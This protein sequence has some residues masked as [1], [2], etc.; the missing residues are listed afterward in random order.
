MPLPIQLSPKADGYELLFVGAHSDDIEIGCGG[1]IL[2]LQRD[3]RVRRVTWAVLTG[4]GER[5]AEARRSA[6]RFVGRTAELCI[7]QGTFRESYLPYT[8]V[9]VKEFFDDLGRTCA[10]DVVF[11]HYR[12]DRHQDH[13]LI[14]DLTYNT[15]RNHSILEYEIPK[16]DGDIGRP[17]V[18]VALDTAL[19]AHKVRLLVKGF[20]SQRD[21]HWFDE[22][23]FRALLRLRGVEA[24]PPTR[25][26]EAFYGR[27]LVL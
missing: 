1:T 16:V 21:K 5:A 4:S 2:R 6:R 18:Y 26:A 11:T 14:S 7:A 13:R 23:T 8:A 25:Y 17:N 10:P 22:E 9:P 27:K 3:L 24:G 19:V 12:D 20:G 15:F